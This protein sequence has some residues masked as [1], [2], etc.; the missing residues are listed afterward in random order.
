[1]FPA[2]PL[3]QSRTYPQHVRQ[4]L[5]SRSWLGLLH[6]AHGAMFKSQFNSYHKQEAILILIP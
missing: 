2:R 1:M 4:L 5:R 6:T 3:E